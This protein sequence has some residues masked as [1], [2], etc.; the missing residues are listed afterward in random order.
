M[1]IRDRVCG[2][3]RTVGATSSSLSGWDRKTPFF[4]LILVKDDDV[5]NNIPYHLPTVRK[6]ISTD[7]RRLY[8]KPPDLRGNGRNMIFELL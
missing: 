5:I 1:C 7:L 8:R 3:R 4:S 6:G 2:V